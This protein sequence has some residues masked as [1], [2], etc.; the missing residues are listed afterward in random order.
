MQQ[1]SI[2]TAYDKP[3][4]S[5]TIGGAQANKKAVENCHDTDPLFFH[6]IQIGKQ[7]VFVYKKPAAI[8]FLNP[9]FV[10]RAAF[11]EKF[12]VQL[13]QISSYGRF[14][15]WLCFTDIRDKLY[16]YSRKGKNMELLSIGR[17][18]KLAREMAH[19]TQEQLA[20]AVGCTVQ[21]ISA[22][23]RGVK[24]PSLET[25]ITITNE[26]GTS[27]DLLLADVLTNRTDALS[28]ECTAVISRMPEELRMRT[29][30]ALRAFSED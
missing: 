15:Y 17:K 7:I 26:I 23:E 12:N 5:G 19:I 20:Y 11:R 3:L 1:V 10:N 13:L 27:A 16:I 22:I 6:A 30:R 8:A 21:H 29:I 14:L 24:T 4:M 9:V 2:K 18:I 25:F 28:C